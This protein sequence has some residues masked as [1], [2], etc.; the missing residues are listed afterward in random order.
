MTSPN[1]GEV[2]L[3]LPKKLPTKKQLHLPPKRHIQLNLQYYEACDNSTKT[4]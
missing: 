4:I 2:S 1:P 3:H